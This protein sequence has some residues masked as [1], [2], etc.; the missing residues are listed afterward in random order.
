MSY[1]SKKEDPMK[2]SVEST[3][4]K[5]L[6][7]F[8][9]QYMDSRKP[10]VDTS[11][12]TDSPVTRFSQSDSPKF[13]IYSNNKKL[14]V[15]Y[16][17]GFGS[18]TD[19]IY[20][21]SF[22]RGFEFNLIVVG[23]SGLGKSTFI[24]SL[25]LS[26]FY[27]TESLGP[28][29]RVKKTVYVEPTTVILKESDV[30]LKLCLVDTPGFGDAVDNSSCWDPI[31]EYIDNRFDEYIDNDNKINR[32]I[33]PDRRIHACLYFIQPTGHNLKPLDIEFMKRIHEKVNII[34]II[35]KSDTMTQEEC[36]DFKKTVLNQIIFHKIKIYD[37]PE[38]GSAYSAS[39]ND[40]EIMDLKKCREKI[41]FAVIG[42]NILI[43]RNGKKIRG[44]RYPW[45]DVE[46][47]N[48]EHNDFVYLKYMLM[49]THL[50]DLKD[51]T[52]QQ[53]YE[54]Y[55]V[56]KMSK[57]AED[58]NF[59]VADGKDPMTQLEM[60]KG[61]QENRIKKMEEEMRQLFE[62]KVFRIFCDFNN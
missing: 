11:G 40:G 1:L 7:R 5:P 21:R 48:A 10:S 17:I 51:V 47:E 36:R 49:R 6:P 8:S 44:R 20:K 52:S 46:V 4:N 18:L 30:V 38:S 12:K 39:D 53:L 3:E 58:S 14:D 31:V 28:S 16:K 50:L 56:A 42:S 33:F 15:L 37:F 9:T 2:T 55:R 26:D 24:N 60:E 22:R 62:Q 23:C 41:P 13:S 34:P 35:G 45:G 57:I 19:Q 25:L 61:E 27:N 59:N 43:D 54:K 32:T 29:K